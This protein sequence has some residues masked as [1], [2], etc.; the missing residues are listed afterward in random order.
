MDKE[1]NSGGVSKWETLHRDIL[2]I[3]FDKLDVM[4]IT[5]G[6]SRVCIS[7]FLAS[8]S[9]TLWNTVDLTKLQQVD[10]AV[11]WLIKG[12][13]RPIVLYKHRVDE[14]V[15][16]GLSLRNCLIKIIKVFVDFS[17][18]RLSLMDL[19]ID[20]TKLSRMAPKNL[21]FNFN[22]YILKED[23]MFAAKR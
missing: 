3:I 15:E 18:L 20:I 17:V 11:I 23:L 14:E 12:L 1:D 22:S 10:L 7:W 6:A 2:A 19:L 4:D 8:H 21:F 16:E 13:V 5:M 9:K